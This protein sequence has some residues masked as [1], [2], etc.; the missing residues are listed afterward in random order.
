MNRYDY[1]PTH[2]RTWCQK[3][4]LLTEVISAALV[5]AAITGTLFLA[6]YETYP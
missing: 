5:L 3:N 6:L 1:T 4:P 2:H